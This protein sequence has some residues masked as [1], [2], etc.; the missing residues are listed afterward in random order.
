MDMDNPLSSEL[1]SD[2]GNGNGKGKGNLDG[3]S[4]GNGYVKVLDVNQYKKFITLK[5]RK[6]Y[7][8]ITERQ[9]SKAFSI[10]N[11]APGYT[12]V[13][14][15]EDQHAQICLLCDQ[16]ARRPMKCCDCIFHYCRSCSRFLHILSQAY[17]NQPVNHNINQEKLSNKQFLCQFLTCGNDGLSK[18]EPLDAIEKQIILKNKVNCVN[19]SCNEKGDYPDIDRHVESCKPSGSFKFDVRNV[20]DSFLI[21]D[22]KINEDPSDVYFINQIVQKDYTDEDLAKAFKNQADLSANRLYH[23]LDS[24]AAESDSSSSKRSSESE[25]NVPTKKKLTPTEY[26]QRK[27]KTKIQPQIQLEKLSIHPESSPTPSISTSFSTSTSASTSTIESPLPADLLIKPTSFEL[28]LEKLGSPLNPRP[29]AEQI[30]ARN[31]AQQKN[32]QIAQVLSIEASNQNKIEVPFEVIEASR[33]LK[34][35]ANQRRRANKAARKRGDFTPVILPPKFTIQKPSENEER[36]GMISLLDHHLK[37]IL[38]FVPLQSSKKSLLLP[39]FRLPKPQVLRPFPIHHHNL[40]RPHKNLQM[41]NINLVVQL[42]I[43]P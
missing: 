21:D 13:E 35:Q 24:D 15:N 10:V 25:S 18:L 7:S 32:K 30:I 40:F 11:V 12:V 20:A 16:L 9:L 42:I 23:A 5:V 19:S 38:F 2:E 1:G 28:L 43:N 34:S 27:S 29:T 3:N 14:T 41:M 22:E 36:I 37:M 39:F 33:S 6:A 4:D 31:S 17:L 8:N 26:L